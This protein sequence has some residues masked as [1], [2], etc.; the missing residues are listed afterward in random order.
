M[1]GRW[2]PLVDH[3]SPRPQ[4]PCGR[5]LKRDDHDRNECLDIPKSCRGTNGSLRASNSLQRRKSSRV[6]WTSQCRTSQAADGSDRQGLRIRNAPAEGASA[7]P[8]R[9]P[10]QLIVYHFMFDP[11]WDKGCPGCTGLVDALGDSSMLQDRDTTFVLVSRAPLASSRR[12]RHSEAGTGRGFRPMAAPS[13][14]TST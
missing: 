9:G 12:T 10:L 14:T 4:Q 8:V 7:R 5:T 11:S 1:P 13:T 6:T 3:K 2:V